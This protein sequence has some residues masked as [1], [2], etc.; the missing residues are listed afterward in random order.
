MAISYDYYR[1][2]YH[3]AQCQSFTRAAEVLNNNQPNISRCMNNLEHE[4][5][6]KLFVRSNRGI[7]LTPEGKRL[8]EHVTIAYNQL[9]MGESEIQRD[10]SLES[11]TITIGSSEAALHLLLVKDLLKKLSIFHTRYPG[12]RIRITNET[13]PKSIHSLVNG[14][15]DCAII[16]TPCEIG[17]SLRVTPLL[18]FE[19][20][21]I[22]G[23]QYREL[24]SRPRSL[25]E[26]T[27]YPFVCPARL[28]GTYRFYQQFFAAHDVPFR[29]DI[30]TSTTD[31]I[32]P[33]I[34]YNLGIGFFPKTL[35]ASAID[36]DQIFEIPLKEELP[37]RTIC[38]IEDPS[39]PQSV[40]MKAF[41][42]LLFSHD[43]ELSR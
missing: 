4:L 5:G 40:A 32:L 11:G 3:I 26:L 25:S 13:A 22:C 29:V 43:S 10:S 8:Y 17:K 36:A 30:E 37:S 34:R 7:K 28:T 33:M 6:C 38:L 1:I 19:S 16:T 42:S 31:Q 23:S 14:N 18:T 21:V 20:T 15:T 35:A 12:V 39:R 2:F 27:P 9:R 24:A 41:L